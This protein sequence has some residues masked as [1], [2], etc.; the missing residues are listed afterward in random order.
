MFNEYSMNVRC[1]INDWV[2]TL[3]IVITN[4]MHNS[5][6]TR[7]LFICC[8]PDQNGIWKCWLLLR[9]GEGE[10][11]N[12]EKKPLEQGKNQQQTQTYNEYGNLTQ[13][14]ELGAEHL[15]SA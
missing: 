1:T 4:Y 12:L 5:I 15:S 11:E 8:S 13:V 14:T 9:G 2:M 6:S 3:Q 10:A 7:W